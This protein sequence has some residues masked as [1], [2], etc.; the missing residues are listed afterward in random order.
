MDALARLDSR[1][2]LTAF[3]A[4][5]HLALFALI[6]LAALPLRADDPL[7]DIW[8]EGIPGQA[9]N[10][11]PDVIKQDHLYH[12]HRPTLGVFLPPAGKACGTAVILCPGG[13][14]VRLPPRGGPGAEGKWLNDLGVAVFI[15]TYRLGDA[16]V[17]APLRDV[18]RAIRIVRSRAAEFHVQPDRIGVFGGSAGGHL[19]AWAST[20][21][22]D[23]DIN[24]GSPLD[25][26]NARPDFAVMLY[27]VITM[28]LPY[29]HGGSRKALLGE[30]PT[31]EQ[32]DRCSMELHVT[33]ATPPSFIVSTEADKS[34]PQ[35]N[36]MMYYEALMKAK[37]PAELHLYEKGP[38]GF[39]FQKNLG[40]TSLWPQRCET[41]LRSHRLIP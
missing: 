41:W 7:I 39:G 36:A 29:A 26:V 8:P 27:P 4:M 33:V 38:H 17:P 11:G 14:Y 10:D 13:G 3:L 23:P 28:R 19:A 9:A 34:V 31:P 20:G 5:R 30:H 35:E 12:V 32:V 24:T 6:A 22:D 16:G 21:Y 37:V 40:D 25:Q 2:F 1:V 15:L 18:T